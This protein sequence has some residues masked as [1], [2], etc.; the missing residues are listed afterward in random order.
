MNPT[1]WVPDALGPTWRARIRA[2]DPR[3]SLA[4]DQVLDDSGALPIDAVEG[5]WTFEPADGGVSTRI[6]YVNHMDLGGNV[7]DKIFT[8]GFVRFAYDVV[9]KLRKAMS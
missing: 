4:S 3:P 6:V 5:S 7:P 9:I 1:C 2:L 8:K